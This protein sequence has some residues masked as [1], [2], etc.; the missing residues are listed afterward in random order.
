[1]RRPDARRPGRPRSEVA[2]HAVLAATLELATQQGPHGLSMDAIARRAGVSKDTL[3]RWWSSKTEVVLEAL[4]E[5]GEQTIPLPDTGSLT[6]D[7]RSFLRATVASADITTQGLLRAIAAESARDE[8]AATLVRD[9]FV[10]NRRNALTQLL[11]RAVMRGELAREEAN[12]TVDLI[13]G[14]LWYRLIFQVGPVDNHWA[15][16]VTNL[17]AGRSGSPADSPPAPPQRAA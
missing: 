16:D 10:S 2:R 9:H 12:L 6:G 13:Y 7:L 11:Q 14:S 15:D 17:I 5:R 1:M 3:Y 8:A 4:S